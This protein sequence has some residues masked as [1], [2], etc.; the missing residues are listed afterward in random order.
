MP[1]SGKS[2]I[3][4]FDSMILFLFG[5][6]SA[7]ANDGF[8]AR[9]S[10]YRPRCRHGLIDLIRFVSSVER[11]KTN[12]IV[13]QC[14][15]SRWWKGDRVIGIYTSDWDCFIYLSRSFIIHHISSSIKDA[16]VESRE[17]NLLPQHRV[18]CYCY[19]NKTFLIWNR[20][21]DAF[22]SESLRSSCINRSVKI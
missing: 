5:N 2:E 7:S 8:F 15:Q 22:F 18:D 17:I 21:R 3:K 10:I 20:Q 16:F 11:H 4:T 14:T 12:P 9:V 19:T 13:M 1:R 6:A